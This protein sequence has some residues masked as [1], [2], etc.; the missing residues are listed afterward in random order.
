MD[1][2]TATQRSKRSIDR[3]SIEHWDYSEP[4][5]AP[6]VE[7]YDR[8]VV[9]MVG[10]TAPVGGGHRMAHA[11]MP[12][13]DA[14]LVAHV[15]DKL[16]PDGVA[17]F[18][19]EYLDACAAMADRQLAGVAGIDE[20]ADR[21]DAIVAATPLGAHPLAAAWAEVAGS[22]PASRV[23]LAATVLR[24]RRGE[25][26]VAVLLAH[27][28]L[29]PEALILGDAW[30]DRDPFQ[31]FPFYGWR[32]DADRDAALGRLREAGRIDADGNITQ[33]GRDER[34]AIEVLTEA[35]ET[36]VWSPLA[37]DDRVRTVELLEVAAAAL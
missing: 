31:G 14:R 5:L 35:L 4:E 2:L 20:L 21:L 24:E 22:S 12:L 30:L 18:R 23:D 3:L 33:A 15:F 6:L 19:A 17:T 7:R 26:H 13:F 25:S 28:L 36:V 37:E 27:G 10:R 9:Y 8:R 16:G 34:A 32:G 11:V 29:G 1:E